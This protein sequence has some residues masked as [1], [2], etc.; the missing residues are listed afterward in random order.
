MKDVI[1]KIKLS[2]IEFK[3]IKDKN[4]KIID[5]IGTACEK[6]YKMLFNINVLERIEDKY[7]TDKESGYSVW[8]N[9]ISGENGK[10]DLVALA[11]LLTMSVNEYLRIENRH[12]KE[13]KLKPKNYITTDDIKNSLDLTSMIDIA[14]NLIDESMQTGKN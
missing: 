9:K 5:S 2:M 11:D 13:V 7:K 12:R 10:I 8:I 1:K 6:E 3:D 14:N 4:G